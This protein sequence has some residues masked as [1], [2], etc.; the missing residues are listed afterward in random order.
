[1]KIPSSFKVYKIVNLLNGKVYIG[2]TVR[3][4]ERRFIEHCKRDT[5][6]LG[7]AIKEF[8]KDNFA[9]FLIEQA[10]TPLLLSDAE[11]RWIRELD[12]VNN[13]YNSSYRSTGGCYSS[14]EA[15]FR[16][17]LLTPEERSEEMQHLN[18]L[19]WAK[20]T[21][22]DRKYVGECM[23]HGWV[24]KDRATVVKTNWA[25]LSLEERKAKSSGI[26]KSWD[27]LTTEER[28]IRARHASLKALEK[29]TP[30]ERSERSKR[31]NLTRK[32]RMMA[33]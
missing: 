2:K 32:M 24:N 7:I 18:Q 33:E 19:R 9:I 11:E 8:G 22:E 1:L 6:K 27:N 4:L 14:V 16:W 13:G 30:E 28:S 20:A 12:S 3:D 17:S 26:A 31:A 15:K 10:T 21:D 29:S 23:K 5:G 25:N